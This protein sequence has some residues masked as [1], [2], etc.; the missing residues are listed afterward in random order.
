MQNLLLCISSSLIFGL[1]MSRL[2]KRVELPAVTA[3]LITGLLL[4]PYC[5][6]RLRMAG[7]GFHTMKDVSAMSI[8]PDTA[9]GFIAFTI[10]NEF[11]MA[12]LKSMGRKAIT[13]GILQA[14]ITT[15]FVDVA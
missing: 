15:F 13:I 11:R 3:Y 4:G 2:A 5:L 10:G 9:L 6:G 8:L 1:M 7:I 14:V 12:D